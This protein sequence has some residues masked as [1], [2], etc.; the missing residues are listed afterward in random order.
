MKQKI[1]AVVAEKGASRPLISERNWGDKKRGSELFR[2]LFVSFEI[3]PSV[4]APGGI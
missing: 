4:H 1:P 2:L 3:C